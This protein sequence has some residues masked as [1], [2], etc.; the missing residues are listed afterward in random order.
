ME[1]PKLRQA[2]VVEWGVAISYNNKK[3][4]Y[5]C[6]VSLLHKV[7]EI[8]KIEKNAATFCC[9]FICYMT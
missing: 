8:L 1:F 6:F 3:K 5:I 7:M 2:K 9:F 4:E